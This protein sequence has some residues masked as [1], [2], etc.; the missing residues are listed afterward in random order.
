MDRCGAH[1]CFSVDGSSTIRPHP[2]DGLIFCM[3]GC[4]ADWSKVD[5]LEYLSPFLEVIR[6]AETSG[7]ITAIAL[8]SVNKIISHDLIGEPAAWA[9]CWMVS[10]HILIL[11]LHSSYAGSSMVSPGGLAVAMH[12][13]SEAVTHCKFESAD[14][15][16]DEVVLSKILQ[17]LLACLK[18]PTGPYLS[19]SDVCNIFQACFR[20]GHG[21]PP[22][23]EGGVS[24]HGI[25]SDEQGGHSDDH[26]QLVSMTHGFDTHFGCFRAPHTNVTIHLNRNGGYH[27][28]STGR[29][30]RT[31]SLSQP[32]PTL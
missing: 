9:T 24:H 28:W 29:Y 5:P 1:L 10:M 3:G 32:G 23:K 7:P 22:G 11:V 26:A 17:V 4:P 16:S 21:H 2:L 6:S 12:N 20:I 19:D 25:A 30:G 13:T 27:F 14:P 31:F 18:C 8:S 15:A